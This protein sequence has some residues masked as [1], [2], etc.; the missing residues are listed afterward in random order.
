MQDRL[1]ARLMGVPATG[2]GRRQS[3]AHTPMPRMTNTFMLAG[4]EAYWHQRGHVFLVADGMGAHA[5]GE[6]ASK[7]AADGI[8]HTYS[9]LLDKTPPDALSSAISETNASIFQKGQVEP[10]FRGM[11]TTCSVLA[12]L[13]QGAL[14]GHVGDSRVYRLRD[15][16]FEQLTFDHSLVW[17][18]MA[19]GQLSD[20]KNAPANVPK[21]IITRSLGPRG[22]VAV[23]L[24]G[25]F[26]LQVG[27][28]FLLC[29]DGLSG[30]V[31]DEEMGAI[32]AS[33]PLEDV[34]RSLIDLAN[35]RGGPD[36]ITVIT[37]EIT[38]QEITQAVS[39]PFTIPNEKSESGTVH[40][41]FWIVIG[42]ALIGAIG[43]FVLDQWPAAALT[44]AA[45]GIVGLIAWIQRSAG[46]KKKG[47]VVA[48]GLLGKGPHRSYPAAPSSDLVERLKVIADDLRQAAS[49]EPW[50]VDWDTIDGPRNDAIAA[51]ES[52]DLKMAVRQYCQTISLLM[53]QIRGQESKS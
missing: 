38:D 1:N 21:N 32:L 42:M 14:V 13:P 23:D 20:E 17:E 47:Y 15:D 3:Y 10:E 18:M 49:K 33:M 27:D 12:I 25:P 19:A 44:L 6:L 22:V 34:V 7:L 40:P 52:G 46:T 9:K 16:R 41:A 53:N 29:S 35:L 5:A 8:P 45:A 37:V 30:P 39:E 2:N 28:R 51:T 26:P 4:D 48:G 50:K 24:E 11:G 43:M 31:V 36:N